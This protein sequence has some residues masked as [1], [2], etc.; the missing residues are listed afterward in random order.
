M[1]TFFLSLC[2][3]TGF[4]FPVSAQTPT[5]PT[6]IANGPVRLKLAHK[7]QAAFTTLLQAKTFAMGGVGVAG[8]TSAEEKALRE[9]LGSKQSVAVFNTL[10]EQAQPAGKIYALLGLSVKD[11]K[12]FLSAK[13][14]ITNLG[15]IQVMSGCLVADESAPSLVEKIEK[16]VYSVTSTH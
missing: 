9:L 3:M 11:Q 1:R 2:F 10:L 16:G 8:T 6:P 4:L 14:Q 7:Q 13:N 5:A 15:N 12:A